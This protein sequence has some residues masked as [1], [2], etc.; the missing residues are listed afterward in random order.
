MAELPSR[1]CYGTTC[2]Q[3]V[4]LAPTVNGKTMPLDATPD[5]A[6]NVA[7]DRDLF[8]DPV[9]IVLTGDH[10]EHARASGRELW[11]PHHATCPDV[12]EFRHA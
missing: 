12:E 7:L 5:R 8:G 3:Q 4:L 9:V 11:M 2:R 1:R 10:L 6:G